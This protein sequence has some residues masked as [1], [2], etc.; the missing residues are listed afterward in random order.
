MV[1]GILGGGAPHEIY[2]YIDTLI[3]MM[4][5]NFC[6]SVPLLRTVYSYIM[7]IMHRSV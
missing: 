1:T 6:G 2:M 4:L 7:T 3:H 5:Y